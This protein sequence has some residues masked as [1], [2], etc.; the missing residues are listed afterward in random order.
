MESNMEILE[1]E[2]AEKKAELER[3]RV[4]S[5]QTGRKKAVKDLSEYTIDEKVAKFDSLYRDAEATLITLENGEYHEDDSSDDEHYAWEAL[6]EIL[7]RDSSTFW[8]YFNK[9]LY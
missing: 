9:F 2:I 4:M 3:L 1:R 5:K 6:M 7:A 8:G